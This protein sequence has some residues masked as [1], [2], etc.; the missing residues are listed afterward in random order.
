MR[1]KQRQRVKH[2][3]LGDASSLPLSPDT[4]KKWYGT[5][6]GSVF[7]FCYSFTRSSQVIFAECL[8]LCNGFLCLL[9]E[10]AKHASLFVTNKI[11]EGP[12]IW[13][14]LYNSIPPLVFFESSFLLVHLALWVI[15]FGFFKGT[16]N[17]DLQTWGCLS[18]AYSSP[19]SL[20][21]LCVYSSLYFCLS[22][23]AACSQRHCV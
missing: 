21:F 10:M 20:F 13:D 8:F 17:I 5:F 2:G 1:E 6:Y 4:A 3:V 22:R 19:L 18:S 7:S 15:V 14:F 9:L 23:H 11:R 16:E 12:Y